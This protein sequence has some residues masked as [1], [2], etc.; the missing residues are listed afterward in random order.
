MKKAKRCIV[1]ITVINLIIL[2]LLALCMLRISE[3]HREINAA[4]DEFRYTE[5]ENGEVTLDLGDHGIATMKFAKDGVSIEEAHIF[6]NPDCLPKVLHFV[7]YYAAQEGYGISRSNLELIGEYR[8]HTILF[9]IGYKPE[10]T[11][12]LNWDFD[13]DPRW[14]VNTASSVIGWCGI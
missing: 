7:K 14:Y 6:D 12:T 4:G 2:I 11:E 3:M 10:Q 5:T 1:I 13:E 9:K 8:L